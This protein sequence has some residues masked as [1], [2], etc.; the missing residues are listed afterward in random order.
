MKKILLLFALALLM[1][2]GDAAYEQKNAG[3]QVTDKINNEAATVMNVKNTK[4]EFK[5]SGV[6]LIM[7]K[8]ELDR[9]CEV[10]SL[11]ML[12]QYAGVDVGKM[13]LA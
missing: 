13:E 8:P 11:A 12:L 1:G 3:K 4:N 10:T 5:L 2:M 6:P 7:Q 9:G